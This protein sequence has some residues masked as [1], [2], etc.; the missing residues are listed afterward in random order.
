MC[1]VLQSAVIAKGKEKVDYLRVTQEVL[2]TAIHRYYYC[3]AR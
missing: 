2:Q 3:S 1:L